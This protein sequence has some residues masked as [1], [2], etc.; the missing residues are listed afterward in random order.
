MKDYDAIF[1]GG[2]PGGSVAA[3][4]LGEKGARVLLL[5]KASFPRDKVCGDGISGKSIRVLRELGLNEKVELQPHLKIRG[6]KIS[7]P[8]G[9]EIDVPIPLREGKENYGYCSRRA[10]FDNILFEHATRVCE[11][12]EKMQVV[13]LLKEMRNGKEFIAGVRAVDLSTKQARD[14]TCNIVIG[15]D[16]AT[17]AV[18]QH[19]NANAM[20][21]EHTCIAV[22]GY[23][24]NVKG[25]SDKIEI[26]F[27]DDF[28]PG[29]FWIFPLENGQ[30]NV[31]LGMVAKEMQAKNLN[32]VEGLKRILS[33]SRFAERF[34]DAI[35]LSPIKGWTL[36]FGSNRRKLSFDG[37]L[38]VGDAAALVDPLTGEGIGN[39]MLS[40]SLAADAAF[41][42][43]HKNDFSREQ[44]EIY[45]KNVWDAL[46]PE[47]ETSYSMQ[48][49]ARHRKL[50][51]L[52]FKKAQ[53]SPRVAAYLSDML[54]S[55]N[56]RKKRAGPASFL[57]LLLP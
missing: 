47:L 21:S 36:P 9:V 3:R 57:K 12:R 52:F 18:A 16:G 8:D 32:L 44:L 24:S 38:L 56:P 46:G 42:A 34:S 31:G 1:V 49:L 28:L 22:R 5:D 43:I 4:K 7:G 55:E 17:S 50:L 14:Y 26:H 30:C 41:E 35:E 40:A 15:A 39:A 54:I 10:V 33:H 20:P 6:V 27:V 45:E 11:F 48:K 29:Y 19:V 51:N 23:Y 2:G 37:A 13:G 25:L 53:K